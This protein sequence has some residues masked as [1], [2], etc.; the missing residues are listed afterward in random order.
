LGANVIKQV[1]HNTFSAHHK[2][3][4]HKTTVISGGQENRPQCPQASS[5]AAGNVPNSQALENV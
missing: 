2:R 4:K 1:T 5:E 3:M